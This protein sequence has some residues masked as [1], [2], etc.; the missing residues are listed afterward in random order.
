MDGR[1]KL[2]HDVGVRRPPA[3]CPTAP[4]APTGTRFSEIDAVPIEQT[5]A[6]AGANSNSPLPNPPPQGGRE[7]V[8]AR[9]L[10][11]PYKPAPISQSNFYALI[12]TYGR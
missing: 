10:Y 8:A 5:D 11:L 3:R 12:R 2:G 9:S 6:A 7:Q 1:V 4:C